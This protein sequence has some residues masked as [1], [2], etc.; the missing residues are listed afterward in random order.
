MKLSS[1]IIIILAGLAL[2][3]LYFTP[4]W[5]ISMKAPQF[6]EGIGMYIYINDV[7]GHNQHDIS[8]INILNH[9]IGMKE[10]VVSEIPEIRYMPWIFAIMI[11]LALI[12]AATG[13][14]RLMIAWLLLFVILGIAGFIDYYLWGYEYGHNLSPDAPIKVPGMS[15][16]PPLIGSKQLLNIKAGSWPYWG[17]L[18]IFGSLAMVAFAV[19]KDRTVHRIFTQN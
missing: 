3:P 19:W 1:R 13:S 16:Q 9:Y 18:Y 6:P 17:S 15:Y 11:G 12:G 8:S 7:T 14:Y 5:T 10:I 2:I 4:F